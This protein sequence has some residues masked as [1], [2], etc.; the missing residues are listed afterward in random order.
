MRARI[1]V[2]GGGIAGLS[3]ALMLA[4]RG[5]GVTVLERD[6]AP[7][8]DLADIVEWHRPGAPQTRQLHTFLGLFRQDLRTHLPDVYEDLLAHGVEEV[9]VATPTGTDGGDPELAVLAARRPVVEWALHRALCKEPAADMRYGT[10]VRRAEVREG[11]IRAVRVRDGSIDTDVLIDA[12][13]RR[14][15]FR[16]DFTGLEQDVDCGV[17][18]NTRFFRLRDGVRRPPLTRG[19]TT[20]VAGDGFGA[21]LFYH[22]NRTFAIGIGRLPDDNELKALREP[23]GFDQVAALFAEFEPWLRPGASEVLTDVAPMAGLRNTLRRPTEDAPAGYFLLGDALCTTDP[24]FGRGASVALHQAVRLATA[25]AEQP[26]DLPGLAAE[27]N[28]GALAWVRPYFDDSVQSDVVRTRLWQA[29]LAGQ[30]LPQ[31]AGVPP[32]NVF[33]LMDAGERDPVLWSAAQRCANLLAPLEELDTPENRERLR[34][35]WSTGWRPAAATGPG[36]AD[37]VDALAR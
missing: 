5:F 36:H 33:T 24:A 15:P 35:L 12:A 30:P 26:D 1:V 28:A 16:D 21:G 3:V 14:S 19:V 10:S 6:Q 20:M 23:E 27:V 17:V 8:A 34:H 2:M 13:G 7:P 22:D 31:G 29:A 32:V 9:S 37:L 11:R 4:R 18:Y 25:F